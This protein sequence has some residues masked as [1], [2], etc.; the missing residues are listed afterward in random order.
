VQKG[1]STFLEEADQVGNGIPRYVKQEFLRYLE[2]GVLAHGFVRV[3]CDNC[4]DELLV[5][6][7]CKSRGVCPSCNAKRAHLTAAHLVDN[8]LPVVPYRQWT[9]SFPWRLR[10]ALARDDKLLSSVLT[11]CL[12][13]LFALQRR[14]AR[15]LG[16]RGQTGAVTFVQRFGSALQLIDQSRYLT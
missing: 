7:S 16:V 4:K 9:F 8:V 13:A 11:L 10:W 15:R 14:R 1:L 5:A 3:R 2:C 12:K 6:F